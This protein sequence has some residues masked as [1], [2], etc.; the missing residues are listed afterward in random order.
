M[1]RRHGT[2]SCYVMGCRRDECRAAATQ[3]ARDIRSGLRQVRARTPD[4]MGPPRMTAPFAVYAYFAASGTCLYVGQTGHVGK[5]HQQ[6][7]KD[8]PWFADAG[9]LVIIADADTREEALG[10]EMRKIVELRPVHNKVGL[11]A[12]SA[13][14]A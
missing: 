2:R 14:A 12:E 3:Y 8:S 9:F 11:V 7:R 10:A 5:R 4:P 1:K 6:H 13:S